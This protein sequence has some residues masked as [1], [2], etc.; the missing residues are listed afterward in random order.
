MAIN[1]GHG[2]KELV[3]LAINQ[4]HGDKMAYFASHKSRSRLQNDLFC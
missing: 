1:Q 2:K 4:D 3:L